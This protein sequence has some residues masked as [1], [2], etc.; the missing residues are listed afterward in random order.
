MMRRV[1]L[2]ISA[3]MFVVGTGLLGASALARSGDVTRKGGIFR[4]ASAGISSID[5]AV[6]SASAYVDASC[7]LL[8]REGEKPEV[9][10]RP[11]SVSRDGKTYT[12]HLRRT[13]R[14]QTGTKVTAASFA[15][16]LDRSLSPALQ[17]PGAEFLSEVVGAHDVI[18]GKATQASGIDASGYTL[19]ITLT[20]PVPDFPARLTQPL[21]CAVPT[22]L[23]A[24]PDAVRAPF[25]GAGPYY[26]AEYV[27]GQRL[28][29]RRNRYYHGPRPHR[30]DQIVVTVVADTPA[31]FEA[32]AT[33][34]ADW[35]EYGITGGY[36]TG[37]DLKRVR[38]VTAPSLFVGY[39][40][41]NT[42]RPL[43]RNNVRLRRAVNFAL[44]RSAIAAIFRRF[45]PA[46][47]TDQ[48]LARSMPGF[49]DAHIYPLTRPDLKKARALA[50]GHTRGGSA[51][52]YTSNTGPGLEQAQ[53][54]QRDLARIGISVEIRAFPNAQ[55]V[56]RLSNLDEPYDLS[57]DGWF[58]AWPDPYDVLNVLL[59]GRNLHGPGAPRSNFARF[60]SQTW[61]G[62][63]RRAAR[64]GGR[65]RY[66]TYG[67]LDVELARDAAPLAAI[68]NTS[69]GVVVSKRTRCVRID[70]LGGFPDLAAVCIK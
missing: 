2:A 14:F 47:A 57:L 40:V 50:R 9:A 64:L 31:A 23:P 70:P 19:T 21:A 65:A 3:A 66:R 24:S 11:P 10:Q 49:R 32:V 60:D 62:R 17:S 7:A 16:E 33:G 22:S 18:D 15:H 43:F 46:A 8:L 59:D 27:P 41:M 13:F 52:L 68:V 69:N 25:S 45:F 44:D 67:K 36:P 63:L 61:N 53:S 1:R 28:V 51:V 58:P 48:Y 42:S 37:A 30:V 38:F 34:G 35:A 56:Q 29:L 4:V 55:K 12:F 26:I 39:L 6:A 20:Q 5:P 54:V